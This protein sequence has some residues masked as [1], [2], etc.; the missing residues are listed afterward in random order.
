ML[1][2]RTRFVLFTRS[3]NV[4][5]NLRN[6]LLFIII[7]GL[8]SF[9]AYPIGQKIEEKSNRPVT[10]NAGRTID[11]EEVFRIR[12]DG[13]TIIFRGPRNIFLGQD[14]SIF[15]LDYAEGGRLYRLDPEGKFIFKTLKSGQGPGECNYPSNYIIV[16]NKIRVQ[17][18]MPSKILDFNMSGRYLKE[19]PIKEDTHGVWFLAFSDGNILAIRD[20]LFGFQP[21]LQRQKGKF[22][23]P[24]S[25]YEISADFSK[26]RKLYEFSVPGV[27]VPGRGE[28]RQG[29]I[30]AAV[31]DSMLYFV[32]TAEYRIEILNL[33]TEKI[34]CVIT[35]DYERQKTKSRASQN[36]LEMKGIDD[37]LFSPYLFDIF[38]IQTVGP[39][40]WVFT[41]TER[42]DGTERLIDIFNPK[43]CFLDSFYL[44]FKSKE[45][46]HRYGNSLVTDDGF[47]FVPEQDE[48]GLVSIGKY[49]IKDTRMIPSLRKR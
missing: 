9:M 11:L 46:Q 1:E 49:Q 23:I 21:F 41:S 12:D 45:K 17:A 48:E 34:D 15:F 44:R 3:L 13:S 37:S 22:D 36:D 39:N 32:H 6:I 19:I 26:W 24:N 14:G 43:G 5:A 8:S 35:R 30:A 27:I 4:G 28:Y 7:L 2:E 38:E 31:K 33:Q 18:F 10:N 42:A 29:M 16:N 47:V 40:L 25:V 20:E